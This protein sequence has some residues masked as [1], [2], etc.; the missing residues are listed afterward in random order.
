MSSY[1]NVVVT[2]VTIKPSR[3]RVASSVSSAAV[4]ERCVC[5]SI[6]H[7]ECGCTPSAGG[8]Q[9]QG[10]KLFR[11]RQFAAVNNRGTREVRWDR[12]S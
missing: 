3:H 7:A 1:P 4:E 5:A 10:D 8:E 11:F 2:S 12:I 6:V 9:K